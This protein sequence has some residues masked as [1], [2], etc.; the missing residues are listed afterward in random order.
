MSASTTANQVAESVYTKLLARGGM[1]L[2]TALATVG[3]PLAL[4]YLKEGADATR[5]LSDSVLELKTRFDENLK[6]SSIS[7]QNL[8]ETF[9]SRYNAQAERIILLDKTLNDR[10]NEVNRANEEQ[11]KS[12]DELRKRVYQLPIPA[13]VQTP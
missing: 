10:F 12:I 11:N 8:L 2:V 9:N 1:I 6:I 13:R 5:K 3:G 7:Q 4:S